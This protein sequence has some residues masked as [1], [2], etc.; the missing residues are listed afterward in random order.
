MT[1][2]I[3]PLIAGNWKMNGSQREAA[4]QQFREHTQTLAQSPGVEPWFGYE[5]G[6]KGDPLPRRRWVQPASRPKMPHLGKHLPRSVVGAVCP[7]SGENF[8]LVFDGM[9][10]AVFQCW[11]DELAKSGP[12]RAGLCRMLVLDN[13]SWHKVKSL[14]WHHFEPQFLPPYSPDFKPFERLWP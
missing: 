14:Q 13:A 8:H 6:V 2:G 11:L 9:D 1:P 5:C 3:R 4:R 10:S 12:L 7:Q